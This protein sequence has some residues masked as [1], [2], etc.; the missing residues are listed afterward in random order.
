MADRIR[1][2]A[3]GEAAGRAERI[4]EHALAVLEERDMSPEAMRALALQT[5][6]RMISGVVV[7]GSIN[8]GKG[9]LV[10]AVSADLVAKG[11]SAAELIS[12]AARLLGGGGSRDPELAQAGG[13]NGTALPDALDLAREAAGSAL[14][15]L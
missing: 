12:P 9:A 15:E 8:D 7:V 10:A 13:P 11:L 6:D 3:A 14:R 4:G 2:E 5:R 1:S